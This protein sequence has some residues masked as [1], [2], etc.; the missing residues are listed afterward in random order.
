LLEQGEI[1]RRG[2]KIQRRSGV[3]RVAAALAV[4]SCVVAGVGVAAAA[5]PQADETIKALPN[6]DWDK[7]AVTVR[8]G[9]TVTWDMNS[10]NGLPHNVKGNVGTAA[11][12]SW[13]LFIT[14][15]K[16]EGTE[17]FTFTLP[18]EYP[19]VCQVHPGMDG[20]VTVTGAPVTPT[21]TTT[22]TATATAT[23]TTTATASPS[24][25]PT[26][27]P[28][29]TPSPQPTT[30][31]GS[32]GDRTTPAPTRT[33]AAD[34][35]APTISKLGLKAVTRGARVS[36]TLSESSTVTIRVKRGK[37]TVRTVRLS[38]R[39]GTRS[40]TIRSSKLVRG[41]YAVEIEARDARGNRAAVQRKNVRV[42]R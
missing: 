34:R 7:T 23:A 38:A 16:T 22:A 10:G 35:T 9:D 20:V 42:T 36:F 1:V 15:P 13:F 12:T 29:G 24:P 37:R 33:S 27:P 41:R 5:E 3:P 25:S 30:N 2:N 31:P 21:A 6:N 18:G 14:L 39:A 40:V 26:G 32:M 4:V 19:F 28:S 17:S 8:T 11:D